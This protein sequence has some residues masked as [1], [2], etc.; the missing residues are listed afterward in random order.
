MSTK[1]KTPPEL[2]A[3]LRPHLAYVGQ[4]ESLVRWRSNLKGWREDENKMPP[5][6]F[7]QFC[8]H[9]RLSETEGL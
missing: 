6:T 3:K 7:E 5:P 1:R 8:K 2:Y 9:Y 4:Y